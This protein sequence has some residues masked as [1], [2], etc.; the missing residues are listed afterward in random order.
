MY[1]ELRPTTYK[2][3]Q[4]TKLAGI[5][6]SYWRF[7]GNDRLEGREAPRC[8]TVTTVRDTVA[9]QRWSQMASCVYLPDINYGS[10]LS[11]TEKPL[12]R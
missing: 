5:H 10:S 1:L 6:Y 12:L 3:G 8:T 4:L 2:E 11:W 7:E 9:T